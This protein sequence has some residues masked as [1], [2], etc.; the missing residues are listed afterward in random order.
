MEDK[1]YTL[2]RE[3]ALFGRKG[4]SMSPDRKSS[5]VRSKTNKSKKA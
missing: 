3:S 2:E 1:I 4:S 5:R